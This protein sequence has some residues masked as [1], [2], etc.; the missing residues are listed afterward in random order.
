MREI[1]L[2]QG[3]IA[4]V[5][6]EDYARLAEYKWSA[7]PGH[8]TSYAVRSQSTGIK[9]KRRIILMHKFLLGK[10]PFPRAEVDHINGDGLDNRRQNLRWCSH[11]ENRRN[12]PRRK[13]NKTVSAYKGVFR[14]K[15]K[16]RPFRAQIKVNGKC[17][18]LGAFATEKDAARAY[19]DAAKEHFGEFAYLNTI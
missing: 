12:E 13:T 8:K 14:H 5:D 6:D 11:A 17:L 19:N 16:N 2:S 7:S 15:A 1:K 18:W 10:P 9:Y 4:I 3:K